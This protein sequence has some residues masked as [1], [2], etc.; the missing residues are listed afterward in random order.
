VG[1]AGSANSRNLR[2]FRFPAATFR[3]SSFGQKEESMKRHSRISPP[4]LPPVGSTSFEDTYPVV[5]RVA[6]ARAANVA[7]MYG[8]SND[9]RNDLEQEAVFHAWRKL[10]SFD[11]TRSSLK[12]FIERIVASQITSSIRRL[13][14]VKRQAQPDEH[15]RIDVDCEADSVNLR[16]DVLRVLDGLRPRE[17]EICRMLADH[18]AIDVSRRS[19]ISRAT[20]YRMIGH[21][22]VVFTQAGLHQSSGQAAGC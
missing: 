20:I 6:V 3:F 17:R 9:E 18:S 15:A 11:P 12:T 21:L 22:R 1:D 2:C 16:I 7:K 10:A 4:D 8:L 5:R 19:G 13:R 14:A